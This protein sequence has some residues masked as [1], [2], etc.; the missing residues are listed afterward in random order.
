[1]SAIRE[2]E[3]VT[4]A[5]VATR[6][7]AWVR[8]ASYAREWEFWVVLVVGAVLRLLAVGHSPFGSDSAALFL[9]AG[10]AAHD[11][12]L[13]GAGI[14]N[15]L[16][17]LNMP[18]YTYLL[19]PFADH[20]QEWVVLQCVLNVAAVAVLYVFARR[21]F[22]RPA[23][24]IA[25]LLF[26]TAC[27]DTY[28][29]LF[30]WQQDL[31]HPFTIVAFLTL[32]LGAIE[33]K[34]HWLVPHAIAVGMV[35]QI[36]PIT[37]LL[38][39]VTALGIMLAWR[40]ITRWD[41]LLSITGVGL[42]YLPTILFEYA[43]HFID[44]PAYQQYLHTP[45]HANAQV[46]HALGQ[47]LGPLPV[48]WLGGD[49]L[50]ART[51]A[52]FGWL[53]A[54]ELV[55]WITSTAWLMGSVL[56]PVVLRL[57]HQ[58]RDAL[59]ALLRS[60]RWRA[61][62]LLIPWP[63]IFVLATIRHSSPVYVHYV[64]V[65][66]PIVYISV[67]V[68]LHEAAQMAQRGTTWALTWALA[69]LRVPWQ[70]VPWLPDHPRVRQVIQGIPGGLLM[71]ASGGV[72]VAQLVVTSAFSDTLASG[73]APAQ[74]WGG[75][76]AAGYEQAMYAASGMARRAHAGQVLLADSSGYPSMGLYWAQEQNDV[77]QPGDAVWVSTASDTCVIAPPP[78][79]RAAV[80]VAMDPANLAI[81]TA[82][83]RSSTVRL[84]SLHVARGAD[85]P[86]YAIAPTTPPG[87]ASL[88]QFGQDLHLDSIAVIPAHGTL[89]RRL[90]THWTVTPPRTSGTDVY[91]YEV[92]IGF[93]AAGESSQDMEDACNPSAWV[94][95]AGMTTVNALPGDGSL[96]GYTGVR[97]SVTRSTHS[98]Y[99]P[100]VKF[101]QLESA[102]EWTDDPIGL[103]PVISGASSDFAITGAP[104]TALF[105]RLRGLLRQPADAP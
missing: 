25:G 1:M 70:R 7:R 99:R 57:A 34:R 31:I 27:Y 23:A 14:Y 75:I 94:V 33:G 71:A 38:L 69:R 89:P 66:T 98:W 74:S 67:G 50:Y 104:S 2:Q 88:A 61:H 80:M 51:A 32:Y 87:S 68:C 3:P 92:H 22:G 13:P 36:H 30:V 52:H 100:H 54:V 93:V 79:A 81:Q 97:L 44:L 41:A 28:M 21:Y 47:A 56:I 40:T 4:T 42:L 102:K 101:L 16:L 20:P 73:Q 77:A 82:I 45:K 6:M 103:V 55:L 24:L 62:L 76:P 63:V 10:R 58:Q 95:G 49:T 48:A 53:T 37:V 64:F 26:A 59:P 91:Y 8:A 12:I 39:P 5:S 85:F 46:F 11:H 96:A 43:S 15:S 78:A 84:G 9:E 60:P 29:S 72:I 65:I 90:V 18:F 19:L 86:V 35:I 83:Q 17:A 105:M